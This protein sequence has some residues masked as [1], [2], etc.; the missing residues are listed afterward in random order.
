MGSATTLEGKVNPTSLKKVNSTLH[1]NVGIHHFLRGSDTKRLLSQPKEEIN[2]EAG[3][4][5]VQPIQYV[6]P[7]V[8]DSD[9]ISLNSPNTTY[10][11]ELISDTINAEDNVTLM[12][13]IIT[14]R[15]N[16]NGDLTVYGPRSKG[17]LDIKSDGDLRVIDARA[18]TR[19]ILGR[20]NKGNVYAE[21]RMRAGSRVEIG[22]GA[23]KSV[24][25][26]GKYA[27]EIIQIGQ[28][29]KGNVDVDGEYIADTINI[30][31]GAKSVDVKGS[32]VST[33][34]NI[35]DDASRVNIDA[36]VN[37]E[38]IQKKNWRAQLTNITNQVFY[39]EEIGYGAGLV[40]G[41]IY[42]MAVHDGAVGIAE[43]QGM[44][45]AAQEFLGPAVQQLVLDTSE[46]ITSSG[47]SV[48]LA[49]YIH[50][51]LPSKDR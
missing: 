15:I 25:V 42:G 45:G 41:A 2:L 50:K 8:S 37:G 10:V 13:K 23:N 17:D 39:A 21:G 51:S 14:E 26:N 3:I 24:K 49:E 47:L 27:A 38:R 12:G 32:Y 48:G 31:Q 7:D 18:G 46:Y 28:D 4:E 16:G 6:S 29:A 36:V 19:L 44:L 34:A 43:A 30:G 5:S 9:T 1:E 40:G 20:K 35:Y 33:V 11:G 22:S